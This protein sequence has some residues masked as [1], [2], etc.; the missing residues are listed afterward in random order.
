MCFFKKMA[1]LSTIDIL[2]HF[3]TNVI[4][5]CDALIELLPKEGDMII[6]RVMFES[7]IPI[8]TALVVFSERILPHAEMLKNKDDRFFLECSDVFTGLR[9]DKVSYFKD[10]W[11]SGTLTLE[12]KTQMWKWFN[13]FLHLAKQYEL[14]KRG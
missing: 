7:Q 2:K 5:F 10:L 13:L 8:E 11:L 14:S 4:K 12:D 3:K 6:L 9:K 1:Q